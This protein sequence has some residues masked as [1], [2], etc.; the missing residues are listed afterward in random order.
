MKTLLISLLISITTHAHNGALTKAKLLNGESFQSLAAKEKKLVVFFLSASCPCT[1]KNIP[2]LQKLSKEY[3]HFQFIGVHSNANENLDL[4]KKEFSNFD[5]PIAYDEKG[6][7]ADQFK[8]TKTPHVFVVSASDEILYHGGVTNSIDPKR[9]KNFY[10]DNAL[11]DITNHKE[12]RQK[13][14]KALGCYIVR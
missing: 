9:A 8:A 12:V 13:F 10:L 11:K 1:K 5:F 6:E 2:Y 4:A 7:I 3:S 14:A